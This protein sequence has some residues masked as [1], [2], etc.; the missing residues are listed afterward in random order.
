MTNDPVADLMTNLRNAIERKKDTIEISSSKVLEAI[1]KILE[2]EGYINNYEVE[3][4]EGA[5]KKLILNLKYVN[6]ESAIKHLER[7]S[8][9][10]LRVY[11]GYKD[12]PRIRN[13]LGM[14]I[15]TTSKGIVSG[16]EARRE[17]IGGE[18]M[19]KIW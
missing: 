13:G 10:G 11:V 5:F 15:I 18:F 17:K 19:L 9:P 6:N 14:S 16:K 8:K 7:V 3:E 1:T 2:K 12:I 4:K